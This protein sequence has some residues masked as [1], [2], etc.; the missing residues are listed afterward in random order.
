MSAP[1][2][3]LSAAFGASAVVLPDRNAPEMTGTLGKTTSGAAEVVPLVGLRQ[4]VPLADRVAGSRLLVRRLG[5]VGQ[6]HACSAHFQI[7]VALVLGAEGSGLRRLTMERCDEI[8]RLQTSGPIG[9]LNVSNAAAV[10]LYELARL[11]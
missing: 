8:A 11:R 6:P 2:F 10:A 3:A 9:S 7:R 5:R 1:S 4:S